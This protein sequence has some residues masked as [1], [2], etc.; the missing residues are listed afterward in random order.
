MIWVRNIIYLTGVHEKG[1][2]YPYSFF[3]TK[4]AKKGSFL[5]YYQE[6]SPS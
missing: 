6:S 5:E 2:G 1:K 3:S 4:A